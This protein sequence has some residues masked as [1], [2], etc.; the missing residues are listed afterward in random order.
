MNPL[1]VTTD[2]EGVA[3]KGGTRV[4]RTGL[5]G[6]GEG[7]ILGSMGPFTGERF[8]YCV[9]WDQAAGEAAFVHEDKIEGIETEGTAVPIRKD[10]ICDFCPSRKPVRVFRAYSCVV[11]WASWQG[12]KRIS[13]GGWAACEVCAAL[14]DSEMWTEM[15]DRS[16]REY[17]AKNFVLDSRVR[18]EVR[19]EVTRAHGLFRRHRI[20]A[21][22]NA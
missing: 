9:E 11:P 14:I 19:E 3:L 7:T 13:G 5:E 10:E 17:C 4:R 1:V 18:A 15:I 6:F 12:V 22:V 20:V 8:V 2:A 16:V 21:G